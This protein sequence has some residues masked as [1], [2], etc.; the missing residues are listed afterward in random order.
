LC[1]PGASV[2][3][4]RIYQYSV[5][6]ALSSFQIWRDFLGNLIDAIEYISQYLFPPISKLNPAISEGK[7]SVLNGTKIRRF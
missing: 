7:G 4:L 3:F 1:Q 2:Q 6:A 5:L